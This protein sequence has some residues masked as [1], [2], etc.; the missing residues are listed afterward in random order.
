MVNCW[1]L[2]RLGLWKISHDKVIFMKL[3]EGQTVKEKEYLEKIQKKNLERY[4]ENNP[5]DE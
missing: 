4:L 3:I 1:R 5:D 2:I